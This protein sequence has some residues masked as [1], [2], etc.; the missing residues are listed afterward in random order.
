MNAYQKEYIH[1]I[2]KVMDYIEENLD[3]ELNLKTLA[4]VA[5]F[6]AYHF[7]RIFSAFTGETLNGFVKRKRV[8]KAA[9]ILLN[10][11]HT[12]INEIAW[13]CGFSSASVFCRNF[14][15]RFGVSAQQFREIRPQAKSKIRQ[16]DSKNGKS[17]EYKGDYVCSIKT[18][19][20]GD[21]IMKN[22]EI[23][24]M[25][26]MNLVYVRHVGEFHL[27]GK[28]YEKLMKWAGPRG[29]LNKPDVKTV[30]V[31]HDDPN[32]TEMEKVRQ[33][34]SLLVDDDKVKTEGEVGKMKLPGGK[35]VVGRFEINVMQF[36]EAW[37]S[38][39]LWLAESGYQPADGYPYELYHKEPEDP[40]KD[41]FILD[42]C[43]PVK[44]M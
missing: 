26:E 39:C 41:N 35:Y 27:I 34:A 1:R 44:P 17:S 42:I 18:L 37:N 8:E 10:A 25:P 13:K 29:L 16:S 38:V 4:E 7:H 43:I 33:S 40:M 2:N 36:E 15:E 22:I 6:S 3:Q 11:E 14:R 5:N 12:P 30:T 31:Y 21:T 28:A 19:N 32:V 24:E 23:K 20:N 9:S